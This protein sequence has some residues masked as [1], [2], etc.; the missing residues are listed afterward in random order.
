MESRNRSSFNREDHKDRKAD[1]KAIPGVKNRI[2]LFAVFEA[3]A[4]RSSLLA[5][6]QI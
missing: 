6:S 2:G 3:F 1:S 4:V 5:E